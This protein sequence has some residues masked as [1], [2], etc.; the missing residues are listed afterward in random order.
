MTSETPEA[1]AWLVADGD[2]ASDLL[3]EATN[4][5]LG[6]RRLGKLV[7]LDPPRLDSLAA[8]I[9]SFS[10]VAWLGE[11]KG[12]LPTDELFDVLNAPEPRDFIV[13]GMV[14]RALGIL[15]VY[16][17]D[18]RRLAIPLAVFPPTG[19]GVGIDPAD[20]EV[21]DNGHAVRLGAYESATDAIFYECDPEYRKRHR[22][23]LR[24]EEKTF[25]A[26]LRRLRVL[27]GLRQEDFDP[28][29]A[30]TIARFERGEVATPR[31]ETLA[32]IAVRLGVRAD[33]IEGY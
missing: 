27:R 26:S 3:A 12:W 2:S 18:F 7:L 8:A 11:R 13:G 4:A 25:G 15:W 14:D 6:K 9:D 1:V 19:A 31:G 21:I 33:E 28:L 22:R 20:F 23:K 10:S 5:G 32:R 24:A 29:T 30:K 16:R 17:G